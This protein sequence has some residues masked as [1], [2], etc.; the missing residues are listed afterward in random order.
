MPRE[1]KWNALYLRR[2]RRASGERYCGR[3]NDRM[4]TGLE[5]FRKWQQGEKLTRS[6]ESKR[7]GIQ[8]NRHVC[9]ST[10]PNFQ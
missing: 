9:A 6:S 2:Q 5:F 10:A 8:W 3:N 7:N 1:K 4:L